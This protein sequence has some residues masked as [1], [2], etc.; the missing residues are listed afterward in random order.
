MGE[1]VDEAAACETWEEILTRV[2]VGRLLGVYS[3]PDAG[4][5][6]VVFIGEVKRG[7]KPKAGQESQLVALFRPDEIPWD[8]LAFRSTTDAL[9]DWLAQSL[10]SPRT[11]KRLPRLER[12]QLSSK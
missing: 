1:S 9:E 2:K 8:D 7:Q 6:T 11:H 12:E 4:V 10:P 5:V 3:Y